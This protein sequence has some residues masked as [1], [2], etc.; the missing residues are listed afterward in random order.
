MRLTLSYFLLAMMLYARYVVSHAKATPLSP[1]QSTERVKFVRELGHE[2]PLK[3]N[4][5]QK[6]DA[7]MS[8]FQ[9]HSI[10]AQ[11][12]SHS[13]D[14]TMVHRVVPDEKEEEDVSGEKIRR[15]KRRSIL[16]DRD[17]STE[18]PSG[19]ATES[20]A[21]AGFQSS[22]DFS[23]TLNELTTVNVNDP[24]SGAKVRGVLKLNWISEDLYGNMTWIEE[25]KR[26]PY[27]ETGEQ[28]YDNRDVQDVGGALSDEA[29]TRQIV[30][31]IR[32]QVDTIGT[33]GDYSAPGGSANG[34]TTRGAAGV[35]V[36][37]MMFKKSGTNEKVLVFRGSR[38]E[39][40]FQNA[41]ALIMGNIL[42]DQDGAGM[43]EILE[44]NWEKVGLARL[45]AFDTRAKTESLQY[46]IVLGAGFLL[47][48]MEMIGEDFEGTLASAVNDKSIGPTSNGKVGSLS[49]G[50]AED[51]GLSLI[52]I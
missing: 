28:M 49:K 45:D 22:D 44:S 52:H 7:M 15:K 36:A 1:P 14:L 39:G 16:Y 37:A 42:Y 35:G 30:A 19:I 23:D 31:Y 43:Q 2:F 20:N 51:L 50:K 38:T 32:T 5:A 41:A 21:R 48:G 25:S 11:H 8:G 46:K 24:I 18:K 10:F 6:K 17:G 26:K 40:D 47:S 27:R 3:N 33:V 29:V 12:V 9:L 4:H 34:G 13:G